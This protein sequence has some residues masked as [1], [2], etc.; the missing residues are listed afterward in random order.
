MQAALRL[1]GIRTMMES[2]KEAKTAREPEIKKAYL[3]RHPRVQ[4]EYHDRFLDVTGRKLGKMVRIN[5]LFNLLN[6]CGILMYIGVIT[7]LLSIY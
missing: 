4:H 3:F 2:T 5:G 6:K 1:L 7:H